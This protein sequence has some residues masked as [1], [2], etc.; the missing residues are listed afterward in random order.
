MTSDFDVFLE[1][2]EKKSKQNPVVGHALPFLISVVNEKKECDLTNNG[3]HQ[4]FQG[5][6]TKVGNS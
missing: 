6:E 4:L 3:A 1:S 2:M 5:K